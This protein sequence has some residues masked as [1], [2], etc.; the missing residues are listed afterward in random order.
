[1]TYISNTHNHHNK[2]SFRVFKLY[3]KQQGP[4]IGQRIVEQH[5]LMY[6]ILIGI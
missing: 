1:M 3:I 6:A 2:T 5:G 4:F